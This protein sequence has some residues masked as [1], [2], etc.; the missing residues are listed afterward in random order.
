MLKHED[1]LGIL[2]MLRISE[3]GVVWFLGI[4]HLTKQRDRCPTEYV[5]RNE[6]SA[7]L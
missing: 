3:T 6:V 2:L 7:F 5:L 4:P 1:E